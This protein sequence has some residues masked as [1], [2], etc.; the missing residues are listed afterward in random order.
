MERKVINFLYPYGATPLDPDETEG[1]IP[2]H[3]STQAELNEWEQ[4]NILEA[5]QWLGK[6]ELN[7][8]EVL[9]IDYTRQVHFK[10]FNKTWKWAGQYR[11]TNKNIGVDWPLIAVYFK[12]LLD[13]VNYQ[14]LHKTYSVDEIA[15]RYHHRLVAL[16]LFPNGNGRHARLMADILL[17]SQNQNR[18]SWGLNMQQPMEIIRKG[19]ID[20]LRAADRHDFQALLNFVRK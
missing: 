3:I 4:S 16:H 20:S 17:T 10:M 6:H 1:L 12:Q 9:D 15:A 7:S 18:F 14:I 5:H 19:Y 8:K 13:D 11:R 2:I